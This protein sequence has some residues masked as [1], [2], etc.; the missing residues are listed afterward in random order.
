LNLVGGFKDEFLFSTFSIF[1][2]FSI[3]YMGCHPKP[4]DS[5][6][7]RWLKLPTRNHWIQ[8]NPPCTERPCVELE[9]WGSRLFFTSP[10]FH[11]TD[12]ELSQK[13]HPLY[14]MVCG[15]SDYNSWLAVSIKFHISHMR[16]WSK[17]IFIWVAEPL[18]RKLEKLVPEL[19]N[20]GNIFGK[21]LAF[22]RN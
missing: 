13:L 19:G 5:Y 2:I 8:S 1:S 17:L 9:P 7:S 11:D 10:K 12:P 20:V 18:N 16:W 22:P 4:I 3:S 21:Y 15:R 14:V 6:F